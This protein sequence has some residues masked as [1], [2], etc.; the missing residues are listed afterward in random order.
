MKESI[1]MRLSQIMEECD[2][3]RLQFA[4]KAGLSEST[5]KAILSNKAE[6]SERTA[7][8]ICDGFGVSMEWLMDGTGQKH[9]EAF[10]VASRLN[11]L[12]NDLSMNQSQ[13]AQ[14]YGISRQM[15]SGILKGK[16]SLPEK[17]ALRICLNY[18][19]SYDW[20]VQGK[21]P[22]YMGGSPRKD[23]ATIVHLVNEIQDD[24]AALQKKF[25]AL[26]SIIEE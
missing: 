7:K 5:I 8:K 16:E 21:G 11:E 1:T 23:T 2:M 12:M 3:S 25:D 19:V 26:K 9:T 24:F 6:M 13:F 22:K 15:L 14:Q 18:G 10:L 20:L 4:T 17:M